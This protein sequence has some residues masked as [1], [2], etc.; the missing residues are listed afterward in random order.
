MDRDGVAFR[1]E[2]EA[3]EDIWKDY[4]PVKVQQAL[5]ASRGMFAGSNS[6]KF[7][8]QVHEQREQGPNRFD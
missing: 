6:D 1:I 8:R 3:S 5:R 4:D 7:L 2:K